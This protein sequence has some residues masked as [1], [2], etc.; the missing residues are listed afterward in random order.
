MK[1]IISF[2]M[3]LVMVFA[4]FSLFSCKS[5]NNPSITSNEE[6]NGIVIA[7]KGSCNYKVV[8]PA[9]KFGVIY[10]I[11]GEICSGINSRYNLSTEPTTD[12]NE[13]SPNEI[14][15]GETNRPESE[16]AKSMLGNRDYIVT[17]INNKL[18]L[19]SKANSCY[20]KMLKIIFDRFAGDRFSIPLDFTYSF[21]ENGVVN[22]D[23]GN[24]GDTISFNNGT[25]LH[26]DFNKMI[27]SS[28]LY[29]MGV[30]LKYNEEHYGR[31]IYSYGAGSNVYI[32]DNE[33]KTFRKTKGFIDNTHWRGTTFNHFGMASMF[34]L[35]VDM[36]D[37]PKGTVFE[38]GNSINGPEGLESGVDNGSKTTIHIYYSLDAGESFTLLGYIDMERNLGLGVWE[39]YFVYE[40]STNRVYCF[41]SD[42]S[43]PLHDQKLVYKYT[44]DFINWVGKDGTVDINDYK[45]LKKEDY[46]DPFEAVACS[47]PTL[48]PGMPV[49]TKMGNGEWF[50]TFE[51]WGPQSGR[52]YYK[53]TTR[54]DDW[55]DV[56]S[57]GTLIKSIEGRSLQTSPYCAW[58]PAGGENGML[59]VSARINFE[60]KDASIHKSD[61]LIS[62]D[63][64]EHFTAIENPFDGTLQL[65]N[66]YSLY[67]PV[68]LFSPDGKTMYFFN[69]TCN[70]AQTA[71]E[72]RFV[73]Y[74]IE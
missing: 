63:Y 30:V 31:I 53:K 60:G 70:K 44:T 11:A 71:N 14:L 46:P 2:L 48:R 34:E 43:D 41:Y 10:R 24:T 9:G 40:E 39:P 26:L 74:S 25:S 16:T 52:V 23:V 17:I 55:G 61:I 18:V 32:S 49:L 45:T 1:K 15:I 67:H 29:G 73:R 19:Y 57:Y 33:G 58:T 22:E 65:S 72:V 62:F 28:G 13:A 47:D 38:C 21:Y 56:S 7:E 12:D 35:P 27:S 6:S 64:G 50:L 36:G 3:A 69:E 8:Y 66:Y 68:I 5:T 20:D 59:V 4:A 54:L 42:D 51:V 37:F